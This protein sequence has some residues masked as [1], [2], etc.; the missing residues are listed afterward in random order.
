LDLVTRR[1]TP[2]LLLPATQQLPRLRLQE[3]EPN[4]AL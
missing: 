3:L 2:A 1:R 4:V